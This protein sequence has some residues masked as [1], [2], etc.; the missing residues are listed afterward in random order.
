MQD[1]ASDARALLEESQAI[2]QRLGTEGELILADTLNWLGLTILFTDADT[3]QAKALFERSLELHEK[4]GDVRGATLSTFHLGI[5]ELDLN[6]HA[7]ARAR[8]ESS[9]IRFR[10]LGDLFFTSRVSSYLGYLSLGE[11]DDEQARHFFEQHLKIDT[12]LQFWDG[13]AEGWR[14][15]GNLYRHQHKYELA[16]RHYENSVQICLDHGLDKYE[17]FYAA[18]LL[19]LYCN[20]Y[21]LAAR[22]FTH[23][24]NLARR[25]DRQGNVGTLLLGLAAVSARINQSERAARLHGAAQVHCVTSAYQLA[26][27]DRVEMERHIQ[28]AREQLGEV[29]FEALALEGQAMTLAQAINLA[30]QERN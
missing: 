12:E 26:E 30:M 16:S 25:P 2:V 9:L 7:A 15:L 13:M 17:A 20:D 14:D 29:V 22:R 5:A 8:L 10:E 1:R 21:E 11:G 6:N 23:Q 3:R 19:A 28:I 4:W 27:I 24:L 18:G